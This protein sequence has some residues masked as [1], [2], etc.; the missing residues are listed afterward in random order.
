MQS[1]D[2]FDRTL[3]KPAQSPPGARQTAFNSS[4]G[5]DGT[6]SK[7]RSP[8]RAKDGG[9]SKSNS[10][11]SRD[12]SEDVH[13]LMKELSQADSNIKVLT[14]G[15]KSTQKKNKLRI[16]DNAPT[17]SVDDSTNS[18]LMKVKK[19]KMASRLDANSVVQTPVAPVPR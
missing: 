17:D 13:K 10:I 9:E 3:L 4:Q 1:E 12:N 2:D 6:R 15:V 19:T 18:N 16:E 7:F 8:A 14:S 5:K 11:A